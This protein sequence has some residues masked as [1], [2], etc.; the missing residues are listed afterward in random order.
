MN[1]PSDCLDVENNFRNLNKIQ[2][3]SY[4]ALD[5]KCSRGISGVICGNSK[6]K[7]FLEDSGILMGIN[8]DKKF[9]SICSQNW[10][11]KESKM[12]CLNLGLGS[13]KNWTREFINHVDLNSLQKAVA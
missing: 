3:C 9:G 4:H 6:H 5:G 13:V 10:T 7:L 1:A 11:L 12:A 2:D 8:Q